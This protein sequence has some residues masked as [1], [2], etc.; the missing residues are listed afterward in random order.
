MSKDY[1]EWFKIKPTINEIKENKYEFS[2]TEIW[3]SYLGI[4]VGDEEDGK[5]EL[6]ERPILILRKFSS[7]LFIGIPLSTK[8]K[9]GIFYVNF[10]DDNES[11]SVLLSQ[12]KV[13]SSKRLI[14]KLGKVS[15]GR[16]KLIRQK[17]KQLLKL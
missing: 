5:N 17:L 4:N 11:F 15:R 3:W 2:E 7:K 6:I 9:E 10:E 14:R 13:F 16:F 1:S 12:V 8:V